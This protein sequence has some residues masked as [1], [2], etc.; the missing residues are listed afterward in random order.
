MAMFARIVSAAAFAGVLSGLLLTALQ[1][2]EIAPLL[3]DAEVREEA[4][5]AKTA[6]VPAAVQPA[7]EAW[8]PH[9]NFDRLLATA[10]ANIVLATG[11]ALLLAAAMSVRGDSGSRSGLLWGAAGFAALFVAPSLGL[12]PE[13][14]GAQA[15]PL[16]ERALWWIGTVVATAA[17]LWIAV[18]GTKPMVR[19][20]GVVLVVTPHVVG[21]PAPQLH[22]AVDW[23]A[24][25]GDF[26]RAAYVVNAGLWAALGVLV[27]LFYKTGPRRSF[28]DDRPP[29]RE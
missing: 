23:A 8:T 13:L 21:A 15:A 7:H 12:P 18:F 24:P 17:G 14:P 20:L 6:H 9:G 19:V 3:R 1:Q 4:A 10:L 25:A 22:G 2:I 28:S 11:F 5:A 16:R 27:G 29:A 26:V